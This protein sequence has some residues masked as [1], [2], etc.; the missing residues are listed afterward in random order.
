MAMQASNN[1]LANM[2]FG[3][4]MKSGGI[5]ALIGAASGA[6]S[7][8]FGVVGSFYGQMAGNALSNMT[9][10]GLNVGRTFSSANFH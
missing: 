6:I 3:A 9:V 7:Y 8:G 1:G 10:A 5:G 2:D 4:A